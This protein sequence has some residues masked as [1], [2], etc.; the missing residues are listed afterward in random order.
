MMVKIL[1]VVQVVICSVAIVDAQSWEKLA[2]G[3]L[4]AEFPSPQKSR[5]GDSRISVLKIDP[6]KFQFKL[7][8]LSELGGSL[9]SVRTWCEE[10][11][12]LGAIN[13]GMYQTDS[14]SSV[15]YMRNF[16]HVNSRA[17]RTNYKS[18][19]MFNPKKQTQDEV[20]IA[21][22]EC[23]NFKTMNRQ[24]HCVF[25]GIR[26]IS[27][28]GRNVWSQ[29]QKKN[30]IAALAVDGRGHVLWLF[31]RSPYSTFDFITII[32]NLPLDIAR[33]MYLEGGSPASMY[34][35]HKGKTVERYGLYESRFVSEPLTIRHRL[36]NVLAIVKK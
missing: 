19:F 32:R 3:L 18:A 22:A 5:V 20:I 30:S 7:L 13:A 14:L 25:Q 2:D 4:F 35:R 34:V 23:E 24:Y 17:I 27:C 26:M 15:G 12:V 28:T 33:A 9:K 11:E 10:E 6:G 1:L 21:D 36:P 31:S 16:D 29:Q 8:C